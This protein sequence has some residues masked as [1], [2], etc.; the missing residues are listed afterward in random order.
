[1]DRLE[2]LTPNAL[3]RL[4]EDVAKALALA[5]AEFDRL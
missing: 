3:V 4:G 1:V 2:D 5:V